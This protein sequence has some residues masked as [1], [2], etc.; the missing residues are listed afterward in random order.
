MGGRRWGHPQE[1][2]PLKCVPYERGMKHLDV[3]I[4]G[5]KR[6]TGPFN[7]SYR[8]AFVFPQTVR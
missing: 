3:G 2:A 5:G 6:L 1:G 4:L 7:K 8:F